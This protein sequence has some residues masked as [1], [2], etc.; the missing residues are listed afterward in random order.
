VDRITLAQSIT[1]FL[2]IFKNAMGDEILPK[3][4]RNDPVDGK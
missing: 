2:A 4:I 3:N 1:G